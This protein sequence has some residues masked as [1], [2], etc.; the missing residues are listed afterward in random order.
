MSQFECQFLQILKEAKL[1]ESEIVQNI[2]NLI[3][4]C[5]VQA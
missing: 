1:D 4:Q 2:V 5:S 3:I